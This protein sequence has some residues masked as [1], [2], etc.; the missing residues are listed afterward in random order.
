MIK[1]LFLKKK[2]VNLKPSN[3]KTF[4][5]GWRARGERWRK[6]SEGERRRRFFEIKILIFS[7]FISLAF[8]GDEVAPC[9]CPQGAANKTLQTHG[10]E[11]PYFIISGLFSEELSLSLCYFLR[12]Y[13]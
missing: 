5:L 4:R 3:F 10:G 11:L 1:A 2:L 9:S 7:N 13:H 8:L 12:N 6:G